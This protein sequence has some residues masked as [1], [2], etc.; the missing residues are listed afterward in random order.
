MKKKFRLALVT[1]ATSGIGEELAYRLADEG[2]PLILT[3]RNEERLASLKEELSKK[4][5]VHTVAVDLSS[6]ESRQLLVEAIR[7]RVPDL[8]INN[9]GFGLY[10]PVV[11]RPI[12]QSLGLVEVNAMAVAELSIAAGKALLANKQKGTIVNIS[13]IAGDMPTPGRA[14]Y[15]ASKAFVT[16]FSEAMD[17]EMRSFGVRVLA[18]LP[19]Y[20]ATR[21]S[22]RA[23][24]SKE[25]EK[26][27]RRGE[28]WLVMSTE[29]AV[30]QI[31]LQIDKE[32][33]VRRF[34]RIYIFLSY[35]AALLPK[36]ILYKIIAGGAPR[37]GK[38]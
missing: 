38:K 9:A 25:Q 2:T 35:L 21:F 14:L 19:G 30:D 10:G 4:V 24:T 20:V 16:R 7:E 5:D 11:V 15:S 12:E 3:G 31:F 34:S 37:K 1:G 18:S 32:Q 27:S 23:A 6:R 22:S 13:S 28:S 29:Y 8:V 26:A 17:A 36:R 33:P